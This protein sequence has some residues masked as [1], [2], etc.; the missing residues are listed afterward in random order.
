MEYSKRWDIITELGRGGQGVV[1]RVFDSTMGVD[2]YI[3]PLIKESIRVLA[4]S[5]QDHRIADGQF[6]QFR[7]AIVKL[8]EIQNLSNH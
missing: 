8:I 2:N 1:Y 4:A 5:V 3:R 7:K 6:E